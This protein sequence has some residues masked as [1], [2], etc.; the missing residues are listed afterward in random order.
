M[1][2]NT[3]IN[4]NLDEGY[5][6][7]ALGEKYIE[8]CFNLALTIRKQKDNRPIALLIH[9]KDIKYAQQKNIFDS[10][11]YFEPNIN[12]PI[13]KLCNNYFEKYCLY[14]RLHLNDYT[15]FDISITIDSDILCQFSPESIW[16]YCFKKN[17][18][19]H[20]IGRKHDLSWH[21]NT[22]NEVIQAYGKHIPHVHGGFFY[23]KKNEKFTKQFFDYAKTIV[24]NYDRLKCKRWYAQGLV[25]EIMFAITHSNFNMVPTDFDEFPIM[26]FNYP[27]EISI[28]SSLQTEGGKFV[29]MK[30]PIPFVHM[31]DKLTGIN[32]N[33]LLNKILNA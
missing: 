18:S 24:F 20:M 31:F 7:I 2:V 11:V 22:L 1:S 23:V 29:H 17:Q 26:T 4:N 30:N 27:A 28:P 8:E 12:C 33:I 6:L 21:W 19:V 15:P 3:I 13:W 10:Y 25:D 5:F 16:Q 9:K 14:P 32:Y